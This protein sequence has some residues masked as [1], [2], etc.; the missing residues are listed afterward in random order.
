[1]HLFSVCA[2][3]SKTLLA[4]ICDCGLRAFEACTLKW[5]DIYFDRC[6]VHIK[7]LQMAA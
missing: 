5:N 1:M 7:I 3:Y 4:V 2:L 6:Q